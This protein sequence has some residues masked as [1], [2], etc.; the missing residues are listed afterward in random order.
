MKILLPAVLFIL[1]SFKGFTQTTISGTIKTQ[2]GT[3]VKQ[4]NIILKNTYDGASSDSTGK[5]SFSTSETGNFVLQYS[6]LNYKEDSI[7][8][9][10]DG[11]PVVLQIVMKK[12]INELDAVT[13]TAGTFEAGDNKRG[14]VLSSLDVATTAG[15][16]A[17]IFAALQTLPGAQTSFAES[18]LFVRGGS[19]AETK[20]YFDGLLIKNPLNSSVPDQASRGRFSPF[21][22]KGTSFSAGG[23]SAQ[24]GQALSSALILESKDLPEKTTTGV[25]LL[26][27]GAGLDQTIRFN[28]SALSLGGFYYN[29]KPAFSVIKQH[30]EWDKEP[31]QYGTTLQ[32]KLKTS[33]N[34]MFKWYSDFS[35]TS[36]SMYPADPDKPDKKSYFSN[37]NKNTY[38]NTTYQDFI[39]G[40][41][42]IQGGMAFS[43]TL[44]QGAQGIGQYN[45]TDR[46]FEGR[47]TVTHY[48]SGLSTL[49]FG[50]E[51]FAF[52]RD[53]GMNGLSRNYSDQLSAAFAES[54]IFITPSLVTRI[55]L[56]TEYSSYLKEF[57]LAPRASLGYKTGRFSQV[58]MAYG[59][60]YQ[61]PED[62]YLIIQPL[63]FEEANHYIL[64]Y[65]YSNSDY[66][67]RTEVYYKDYN[68]LTRNIDGFLNNA[69]NGFARGMELF[70]RDRKS[71]KGV[72]YW[73]SYSFLDTKRK[74]G[75]YPT[76]ATPP[77]AAKHTLNIVYKQYF[78]KLKSQVGA[79]YTFASG[80][81]YQNPNNAVYLG[82][83]TR[84]FNNF[85]MNVSY[86]T[87]VLH[88]FTILYISANNIFG[89]NNIYGYHYSTDGQYRKAIQPSAPRDLFIGLMLTIGDNTFV[90]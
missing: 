66:T 45:R 27:V 57:N 47:A 22:F 18:G 55:G 79:T 67:F 69:G 56:R 12:S 85:S 51:S 75:D 61:N 40:N 50:A 7:R 77:F 39:A 8:V 26:T 38:I 5:F 19:A 63:N 34:G 54:E 33:K 86:L 41:W 49:K 16:T 73:L 89:F 25:S 36:L 29:L 44:D 20:T 62:E 9:N 43:N 90:R 35:R 72:D 76:S 64:N 28:N 31:E 81:T 10:L 23:Y 82:D 32:Y 11:K 58:S 87:S 2:K 59:R 88:Q 65:Q 1:I 15:A 21:L 46:L 30:T 42:K 83:K 37:N 52:K 60:F 3:P 84:N 53:E 71:I 78:E 68:N 14:T 6:A 17:D 70:W 74:F 80:R 48:L 13:I 24:Y 4:A